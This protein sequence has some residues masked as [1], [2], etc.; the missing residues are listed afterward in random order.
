MAHLPVVGPALAASRALGTDRARLRH[1][2]IRRVIN[3]LVMD[4]T[5]ET[6][7]RLTALAPADADAVR[8]ADH[9]VVA[10]SPAMA[11]ANRAIKAFLNEHMYRHWR[12]N[13]QS[14]RRA[15]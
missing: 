3:A 10:F 14:A 4:L 2:T 9:A 12:V 5:A 1:E 8:A 6:R 11:E 7:R 15:G 13:R